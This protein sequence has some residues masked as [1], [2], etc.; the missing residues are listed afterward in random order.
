[1]TKYYKEDFCSAGAVRLFHPIY[2]GTAGVANEELKIEKQ[3]RNERARI[4]VLY[5]HVVACL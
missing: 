2:K 1:L 4:V 3:Q 5:A